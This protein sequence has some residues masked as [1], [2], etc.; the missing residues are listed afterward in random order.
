MFPSRSVA[1]SIS[2]EEI[3]SVS[4]LVIRFGIADKSGALFITS[5]VAWSSPPN[6]RTIAGPVL[7]LR[8]TMQVI[9]VSLQDS[10]VL[11]VSPASLVNKTCA[12]WLS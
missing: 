9:S 10:I 2:A 7:A 12:P 8:G 1:S 4:F 6:V 11:D 3:V 5:I